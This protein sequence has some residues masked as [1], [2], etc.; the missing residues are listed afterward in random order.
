[1]ELTGKIFWGVLF[2]IA[3]F[4]PLVLLFNLDREEAWFI[5]IGW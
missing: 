2:G 3:V 5:G 1:M 4:T